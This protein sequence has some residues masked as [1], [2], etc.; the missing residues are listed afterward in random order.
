M[1]NKEQIDLTISR[2]EIKK[3]LE[4]IISGKNKEL[5]LKALF[6]TAS[7]EQL[8]ALFKASM[9]I[10]PILNYSIGD[11]ILVN[12]YGLSTWDFNIDLMKEKDLITSYDSNGPEIMCAT[13]VDINT[14]SSTPYEIEVEY[15]HKDNK[16]LDEIPPHITRKT[17]DFTEKYIIG[18]KEEWPECL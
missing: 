2:A 13:I 5:I 11:E 15:F 7:N 6:D 10:E 16:P 12:L 1:E 18:C 3:S 4:S 14:Y 9:G 8:S 17:Q